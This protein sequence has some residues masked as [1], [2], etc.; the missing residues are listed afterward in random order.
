MPSSLPNKKSW[1]GRDRI[2]QFLEDELIGP[3][4]G[5]NETL[6]DEKPQMRYTMGVLFPKS[7]EVE[8]MED[9]MSAEETSE[10]PEPAPP[11]EDRVDDPVNL[12][13]Q[14]MPASIGLSFYFEDAEAFEVDVWGATYEEGDDVYSRK[15]ISE[16]ASPSSVTV[17]CPEDGS[18]TE[19]SVLDGK[20]KLHT[21]WRPLGQG[22]LVTATLIN[23]AHR[24]EG[25]RYPD[26]SDCLYQIGFKC[27]VPNGRIREYPDVDRAFAGEEERELELMYRRHKTFAI[28]HGCAATWQDG[29][30]TNYVATRL[31]PKAVVPELTHELAPQ[32][33]LS[34]GDE[35]VLTL[36]FLA[37]KEIDKEELCEGLE[38]FLEKYESWIQEAESRGGDLPKYL[39]PAHERITQRLR[40]VL[41]R[42]R[43]GVERLRTDGTAREAFRLANLAMLMQMHHGTDELGGERSRRDE[44]SVLPKDFDYK[45]LEGYAW[46]PFQ[47]AFQLLTLEGV[48]DYNSEERQIVDLIWFPTGGGK[49]E[50]Y[51][52]VAAYEILRRRL[53][54][55]EAG[56]GT[57]VITRYTL[58]LLTSQQFQ[59]SAL[60]SAFGGA[61]RRSSGTLLSA[62]GFGRVSLPRP[63]GIKTPRRKDAT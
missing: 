50:A 3:A 20:A 22:Y 27:K 42:M 37:S 21:H 17:V 57:A 11:E 54:H 6:E 5:K 59:R 40:T 2:L 49:T 12:S 53:V 52:A 46:R 16:E 34:D 51:L 1:E 13:N 14:Q 33:A 25:E 7:T 19:Q 29:V 18:T 48:T 63:T 43:T 56:A 15:P 10:G 62:L 24:E 31:L 36:S 55:R 26:A 61:V 60:L 44:A 30:G 58:R 28:G 32:Y 41:E 4:D 35:E 47:L 39:V 8:D 38:S 45:D 23:A 9:E